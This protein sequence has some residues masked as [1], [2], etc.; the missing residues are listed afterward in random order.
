MSLPSVGLYYY[1]EY[2][3]S[4]LQFKPYFGENRDIA[5]MAY[6]KIFNRVCEEYRQNPRNHNRLPP[7]EYIMNFYMKEAIWKQLEYV[8]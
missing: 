2:V 5:N 7:A 4:E 1:A 6:T 8:L 3:D